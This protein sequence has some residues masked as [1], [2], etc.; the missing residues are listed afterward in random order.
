MPAL[1]REI[2]LSPL[3][4]AYGGWV[5]GKFVLRFGA[6]LFGFSQV[7]AR[8]LR[9]PTCGVVND[10]RG[11]WT[12]GDCGAEYLGAVDDCEVCGAGASWFPCRACRAGIPLRGR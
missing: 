8:A 5:L 2:L 3:Y 9:C 6:A 12:C 1:Y 10:L 4:A 7:F 11:R